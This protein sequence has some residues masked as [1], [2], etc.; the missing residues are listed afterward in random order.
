MALDLDGFAV[1][2]GAACSSGKVKRSH[3]LAA[4]DRGA[5]DGD[6]R[7]ETTI[8]VSLGHG[9]TEDDVV[10]LPT[11]GAACTTASP[12]AATRRHNLHKYETDQR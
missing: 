4:M 11:H 1:S 5:P 2:A 7:A 6:D 9:T 3:V 12:K 10:R 8:R